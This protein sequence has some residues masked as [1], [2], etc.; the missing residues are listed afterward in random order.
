[1]AVNPSL[2]DSVNVSPGIGSG[3]HRPLASGGPG[4]VRW[5]C[6]LVS[7]PRQPWNRIGAAW[8]TNWIPSA[9]A[10]A[11]SS[12]CAGMSGRDRR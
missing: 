10:C 1:M 4:R 7:T 11:I 8:K 12:G 2:H 9:S 3:E 6:T 5:Q